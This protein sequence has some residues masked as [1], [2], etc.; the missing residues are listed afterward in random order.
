MADNEQNQPA[1]ARD[2]RAGTTLPRSGTFAAC[3]IDRTHSPNSGNELT[4]EQFWNE[5][6]RATRERRDQAGLLHKAVRAAVRAAVGD[7]YLAYGREYSAYLYKTILYGKHLHGAQ[8]AK[9]L[10]VGSAPGDH[11]A[12]INKTYGLDVYGVEYAQDGVDINRQTFVQNG[13]D[14]DHVIFADF[15]SPE[16][17]TRYGQFFD[18]VLSRGFIEHFDDPADVIGK[19][20]SLLKPG[21]TLIVTVP[22]FIGAVYPLQY[23]LYRDLL[24][25][26]N[27]NLMREDAFARTFARPD[28]TQ[29]Y[30]GYYGGFTLG[31][32]EVEPDAR[33]KGKMLGAL[34]KL[35]MPLNAAMRLTFGDRG[36]RNRLFTS[37][38]LYVGE[39]TPGQ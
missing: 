23:V 10:E 17:Q 27:L 5:K 4:D 18:F 15:F 11:L 6:Y 14:P 9:L 38:L 16:F 3:M 13:L 24:D 20:L 1:I 8:G 36:I 37:H 22:N 26:H 39:K 28:L 33:V 25:R 35:Q 12:F 31:L 7:E 30:C 34:R 32:I 2:Q 19:H 29:I 21:G